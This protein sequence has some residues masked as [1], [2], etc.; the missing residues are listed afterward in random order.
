MC[1]ARSPQVC[2]AGQACFWFSQG[3]SI[4]CKSATGNGTRLPNLDHC[5]DERQ[6]SFDPLK[7]EGALDPKYR[8]TN[9]DAVPGSISD[10]WKCSPGLKVSR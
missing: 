1:A 3:T 4:G 8:T 2:S 6:S 10:V 5:P 7:M 9:I